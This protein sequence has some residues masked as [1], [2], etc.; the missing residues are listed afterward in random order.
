MIEQS[1]ADILG[2]YLPSILGCFL[3]D[4]EVLIEM[5]NGVMEKYE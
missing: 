1:E 2:P 4:L 5:G 3:V